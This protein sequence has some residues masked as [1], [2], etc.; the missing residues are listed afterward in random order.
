MFC[1]LV[2]ND[3]LEEI[4]ARLFSE[5]NTAWWQRDFPKNPRIPEGMQPLWW[6]PEKAIECKFA[7]SQQHGL[8]C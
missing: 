4:I 5:G 1:E 3:L 2:G 6:Q 7:I 8:S